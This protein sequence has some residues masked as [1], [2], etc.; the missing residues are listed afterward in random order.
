MGKETDLNSTDRALLHGALQRLA[1]GDRASAAVVFSL[2]L[3]V[4]Q[5]TAAR[6]LSRPE[7]AEEAAQQALLK[8]FERASTFDPA[9][10]EALPW[11]VAITVWECRATRTRLA[12][13]SAREAPPPEA[14]SSHPH[15]DLDPEGI[16]LDAE[17][18]GAL[19]EAMGALL[20]ADQET[21]AAALGWQARPPVAA[22][23]FRQRL[24]RARLRL[25]DAWRLRDGAR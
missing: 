7:D 8:V 23:T 21:L 6:M 13:C 2:A 3:P 22:G 15:P 9:R 11:V 24:R 20:P 25:Q 12:R 5:A 4:A 18:W 1:A 14:T 17:L 16:L 19:S 10:G